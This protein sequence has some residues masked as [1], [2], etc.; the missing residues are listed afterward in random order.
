[1]VLEYYNFYPNLLT[2]YKIKQE[3]RYTPKYP[4]LPRWVYVQRVEIVKQSG[5][6]NSLGIEVCTDD[7]DHKTVRPVKQ[8]RYSWPYGGYMVVMYFQ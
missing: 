3:R 5:L 6:W 4:R 7:G 2:K 8:S 1:M